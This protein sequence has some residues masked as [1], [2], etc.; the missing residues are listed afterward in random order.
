MDRDQG[1]KYQSIHCVSGFGPS[2]TDVLVNIGRY[3]TLYLD[4][5][6]RLVERLVPQL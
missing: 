6:L 4:C 5:D 1:S 2:E 3:N